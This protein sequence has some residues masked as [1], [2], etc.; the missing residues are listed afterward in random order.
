M[1]LC[2]VCFQSKG[3]ETKSMLPKL[4][5]QLQEMKSRVQFLELVKKYVQASLT[6]FCFGFIC[7]FNTASTSLTT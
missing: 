5:G 2:F 4:R 3:L 7:N 6:L 1:F